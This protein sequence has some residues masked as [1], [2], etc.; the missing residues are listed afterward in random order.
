MAAVLQVDRDLRVC[1]V[2]GGPELFPDDLLLAGGRENAT[3]S[4][5]VAGVGQE[6]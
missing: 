3:A 4:R 5:H 6:G 1:A 2:V